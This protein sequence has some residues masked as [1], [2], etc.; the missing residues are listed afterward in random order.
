MEANNRPLAL[1]SWV[2]M[3]GPNSYTAA[4]NAVKEE[5]NP[6]KDAYL[7]SHLELLEFMRNAAYDRIASQSQANYNQYQLVAPKLNQ[8]HTEYIQGDK[9]PSDLT[10]FLHATPNLQSIETARRTS[11]HWNMYHE[12]DRPVRDDLD[13]HPLLFTQSIK[14]EPLYRIKNLNIFDATDNYFVQIDRKRT[15]RQHFGGKVLTIARNS[16]VLHNL[17]GLMPP[18]IKQYVSDQRALAIDQTRRQTNEDYNYDQHSEL[19]RD[20][21]EEYVLQ[22]NSAKHP[23]WAIPIATGYYAAKRKYIKTKQLLSV[24]HS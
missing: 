11:R 9:T 10:L 21:L 15:V 14:S 22:R 18:E 3:S 17:S 24:Q 12:V 19:L 20:Y 5:L 23:T 7:G 1:N 2:D 6:K 16:L 13:A 4:I 8:L